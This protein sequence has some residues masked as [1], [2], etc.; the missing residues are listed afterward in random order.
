MLFLDSQPQIYQKTFWYILHQMF[1]ICFECKKK[2]RKWKNQRMPEV[3]GNE[4]DLESSNLSSHA[5]RC[6]KTWNMN[7]IKY[8]VG[9][10]QERIMYYYYYLIQHSVFHSSPL[11]GNPFYW[12]LF[13]SIY[14]YTLFVELVVK[15][16][17]QG[18]KYG[19]KFE[20]NL[21]LTTLLCFVVVI[22]FPEVLSS[23]RAGFVSVLH[24]SMP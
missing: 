12:T 11:S 10:E 20:L 8:S 22:P 19:P 1:I 6:Q 13:Q 16:S 5:S 23:A 2:K 3:V 15:N 24:S 17:S 18:Q 9:M 4:E 14:K 21:S 7:I